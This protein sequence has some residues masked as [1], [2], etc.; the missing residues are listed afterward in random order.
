MRSN[1]DTRGR[2]YYDVFETVNG[3]IDLSHNYPGVIRG[4]HLHRHKDETWV[5]IKGN[6]KVVLSDPVEKFYLSEGET[7]FIKRGRWHGFQVL[8]NEEAIMLEYTTEKHDM[9]N[10]DDEREVY[11]K[12][13]KWEIEKK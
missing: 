6:F 10:L 5:C 3:Q 8:G 12:F 2:S 4:F 7:V 1:K 9:N 11:D 13:D